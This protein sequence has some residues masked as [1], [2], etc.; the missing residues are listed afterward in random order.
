M[1]SSANSLMLLLIESGMSLMYMRN[2]QGPNTDPCGTPDSTWQEPDC[3]PSRTTLCDLPD[4]CNHSCVYTQSMELQQ[5]PLM[6]NCIK[7]LAEVHDYDII[8][9]S[10]VQGVIQVLRKLDELGLTTDPTPKPMLVVK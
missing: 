5:K 1:V 10:L 2:R 9:S 8:L 4:P 6:V 7:C 3:S